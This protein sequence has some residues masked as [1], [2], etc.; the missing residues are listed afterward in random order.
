MC[1]WEG[2]GHLTALPSTDVTSQI[3]FFLQLLFLSDL[4]A[5]DK[6]WSVPDL[7]GTYRLDWVT[8]K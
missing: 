1:S 6:G 4:C 5:L 3:L 7:E 8:Q 2:T